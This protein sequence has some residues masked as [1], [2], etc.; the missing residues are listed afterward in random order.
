MHTFILLTASLA[1]RARQ[2]GC[3]SIIHGD[4]N[5]PSLMFVHYH[6]AWRS[7]PATDHS[8][9]PVHNAVRDQSGMSRLRWVTLTEKGRCNHTSSLLAFKPD[10]P[11]I[12]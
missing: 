3:Q 12:H 5:P 2:F 11:Q 9:A 8:H 7:Y 4:D 6:T 10:L 1:A